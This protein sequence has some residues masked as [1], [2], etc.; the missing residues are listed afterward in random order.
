MRDEIEIYVDSKR[1]DAS[2]FLVLRDI[3]PLSR[4]GFRFDAGCIS[5]V[6]HVL[7]LATALFAPYVT[8]V[9]SG[10]R[11]VHDHTSIREMWGSIAFDPAHL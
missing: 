3:P 6:Y 8:E 5:V 10:I 7:H 9:M 1:P 11:L 4:I 2:G